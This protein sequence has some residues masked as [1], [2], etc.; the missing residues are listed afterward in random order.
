MLRPEVSGRI[1]KLGF[2]DGQRVRRRPAAG[3]ARRHAA[4]R[5]AAAGA[6][7]ASI[8]RTNLQRN[9]TWWRRTSSARARS[10]RAAAPRG[11]RSAGG[12]GAGTAGAHADRRAVRRR[13]RHPHRQRWRLRERRRRP[14]QH[15]GPVVGVRSTSGCPSVSWRGSSPGRRSRSRSTRC[16]V[17]NFAGRIEAVDSQLDANGRSLLVRARLDNRGRRAARRAC[18]RA[19]R[20]VFAVRDERAGRARGGAGA[21]GRQ[22]VPGQGGAPTADGKVSQRIEARIGSRVP[23]KVEILEG[24]TRR[25][26]GR[27]RRPGAADARRRS[28]GARGRAHAARR[29]PARR[30]AR[31]RGRL[32]ARARN[33]SVL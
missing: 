31:R 25:R 7:Q 27:H 26:H 5:A 11:G 15:R 6:A 12:A 22:A 14:G 18:S 21:A 24:L 19:S 8:A 2:S 1:A 33:S 16:P 9:R 17:G 32:G 30:G 4:A 10:T 3:A 28:A 20:I 13:R 29:Q 23:G